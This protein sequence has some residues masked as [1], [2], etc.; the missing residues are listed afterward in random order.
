MVIT[1]N[2]F[3]LCHLLKWVQ[4]T[5]RAKY[6]EFISLLRPEEMIGQRIKSLDWPFRESLRIDEAMH[7]LTMIATVL[8]GNWSCH[9]ETERCSSA[10]GR[11]L[12]I[13]F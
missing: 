2:I 7:P 9:F 1:W 13:R 3:S 5:S 6:V 11:T 4:L 10:S 12:E 8:Y